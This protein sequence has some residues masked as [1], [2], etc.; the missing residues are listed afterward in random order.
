MKKKQEKQKRSYD[1]SDAPAE[2]K[3]KR[4]IVR[5][6]KSTKES[7][8]ARVPNPDSLF[9]LMDYPEDDDLEFVAHDPAVVLEEQA[10]SE[11][12]DRKV[13]SSLV[14][15]PDENPTATASQEATTILRE[16]TDIIDVP[17]SPSLTKY[18]FDEA[19][20]VIEKLTEASRVVGKALYLFFEVMDVGALE[21]YFGFGHLKIP[22]KDVLPRYRR[23]ELKPRACEEVPRLERRSRSQEDDY[24]YDT[25]GYQGVYRAGWYSQLPS[26]FG[27]LS[28]SSKD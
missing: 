2:A 5:V 3:K 16:A 4:V 19:H 15:E 12:G 11:G 17:E 24:V 10:T 7:T 22:R 14:W 1:P 18:L 26:L 27:N 21:D 23:A 8:R 25:S 20:A 6:R 9:W 13:K 28:G